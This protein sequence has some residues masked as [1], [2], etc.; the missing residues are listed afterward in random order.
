MKIILSHISKHVRKYNYRNNFITLCGEGVEERAAAIH[1]ALKSAESLK[2]LMM[3]E[4]CA[5]LKSQ[6]VLTIADLERANPIFMAKKALN[7]QVLLRLINAKNFNLYSQHLNDISQSYLYWIEKFVDEDCNSLNENGK[8]RMTAVA[9][10]ELE[11]IRQCIFTAVES[12]NLS[13]ESIDAWLNKFHEQLASTIPINKEDLFEFVGMLNVQDL[14]YF[15]QEFL[16]LIKV[17]FIQLSDTFRINNL[18]IFKQVKSA[19]AKKMHNRLKGCC[20]QCPFC[21]EECDLLT[22][23][24]PGNHSSTI[25]RP[26]CLGGFRDSETNEMILEVCN[27]AINSN[28]RFRC[29]ATNDE[30]VPYKNYQEY[31]KK[32]FIDPETD[33]TPRY[34]QWFIGKYSREIADHCKMNEVCEATWESLGWKKLDSSDAEQDVEE[35]YKAY[36]PATY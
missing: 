20:E 6:L 14:Q 9:E 34:W 2:I 24:H 17:E 27:V 16:S 12:T 7:Q 18:E 29:R 36:K 3:R 8:K 5:T 4:M 22:V 19:V 23:N 33:S 21:N 25:H 30:Y 13:N 35:N 31:F 10:T 28:R 32:W 26:R 11:N 1:T 15:K